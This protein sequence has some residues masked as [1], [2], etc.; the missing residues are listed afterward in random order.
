M[1]APVDNNGTLFIGVLIIGML[2]MFLVAFLAAPFLLF[3]QY[4]LWRRPTE[5][6]VKGEKQ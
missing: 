5:G 6:Y 2:S 1:G 4:V 3:Y